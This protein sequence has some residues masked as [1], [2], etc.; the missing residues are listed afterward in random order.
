[1][2]KNNS[3]K[4]TRK[5]LS[6][7][8]MPRSGQHFLVRALEY[9]TH[10]LN[11]KTHYCLYYKLCKSVPCNCNIPDDID[12]VFQKN[13]DFDLKIKTNTQTVKYVYLYRDSTINCLEANYRLKYFEEQQKSKNKL[14]DARF[15]IGHGSLDLTSS[16]DIK[17]DD[18]EFKNFINYYKFFGKR[19]LKIKEK[20][21]KVEGISIVI[22]EELI[23]NFEY[24]FT[25][26]LI[27]MNIP[28]NKELIQDTKIYSNPFL[29]NKER[30]TTEQINILKKIVIK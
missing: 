30:F 12:I 11:I 14:P 7:I 15:G 23:N 21:L 26:L 19:L 16:I 8:S 6:I 28:I 20:W 1:M 4:S 18:I 24:E 9:Y 22:Y 13:H 10:K 2:K 25:K 5:I 17:Y 27:N 29:V 3:S